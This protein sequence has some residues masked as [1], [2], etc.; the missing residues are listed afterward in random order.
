MSQ[1]HRRQ[2]WSTASPKHRSR[3][4]QLLPLPCIECGRPVTPD[5]NWHVGHKVAA[6]APGSS[7]GTAN[8]GPAHATCNLKAGGK[9]G[10]AKTNARRRAKLQPDIRDWLR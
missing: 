1:H 9:L 6:S 5:Q 10:A 8:V 7:A 3:I 2:K 4:A